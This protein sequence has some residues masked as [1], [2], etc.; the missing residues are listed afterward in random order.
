M[1]NIECREGDLFAPVQGQTFDLVF[2]NPPFVIAP[3]QG[4][5]HTYSGLPA[6]QLCQTI[7]QQAP[8]FLREG[9]Y[10]QL[11]CN[12]IQVAGQDWQERLASWFEGTGCDVWVLHSHSEEVADYAL[13][14]ISEAE[15]DPNSSRENLTN[16]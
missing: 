14:R 2:C 16:G 13:K 15:S 11:L 5:L 10:C 3:E 9:G 4:T 12:W 6:D 8:T 7:V 1:V